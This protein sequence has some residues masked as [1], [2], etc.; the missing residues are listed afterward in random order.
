MA[1]WY[2]LLLLLM[3]GVAAGSWFIASRPEAPPPELPIET[4][5]PAPAASI[6]LDEP[7]Q[8]PPPPAAEPVEERQAAPAAVP[9][10]VSEAATRTA[11]ATPRQSRPRAAPQRR[12]SARPLQPSADPLIAPVPMVY[13]S[14]PNR[15]RLVQLGAFPTREEADQ[16]WRK[17]TRRY[18]YL[19]TKPRTVSPIDIG[20]IGGGRPTRLYRLQLAT[21]SQAQS[22]VI[23]QQLERAGQSCVVVY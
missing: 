9:A 12:S 14:D 4:A 2:A 5:P 16:A 22:V 18:P 20:S 3:L 1:P 6:A 11:R 13:R 7:I 21:A 23:C 10:R 15:G 17:V 19:A 8:P